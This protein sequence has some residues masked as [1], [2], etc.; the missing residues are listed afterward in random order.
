M[1]GDAPD[2]DMVQERLEEI[3]DAF[4]AGF[5]RELSLAVLELPELEG[6][7][8]ADGVPLTVTNVAGKT[9]EHVCGQIVGDF[10]DA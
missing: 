8:L 4:F 6:E 3:V 5:T 9:Y 7:P 10:G 1:D 2:D